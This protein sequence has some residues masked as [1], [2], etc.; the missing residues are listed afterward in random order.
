MKDKDLEKYLIKALK[1]GLTM[2]SM[3]AV[4]QIKPASVVT[5][6]WVRLKCQFGCDSYNSNYC[7]PPY[8]P[9]PEETRK[10]LDSYRRALLFHIELPLM[11]SVSKESGQIMG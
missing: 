2:G 6:P 8:T 11:C 1:G 4:K 10:I 3:T 9:T 5:A 7:C